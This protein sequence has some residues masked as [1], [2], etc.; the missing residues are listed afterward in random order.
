MSA[1]FA[2]PRIVQRYIPLQ[3]HGSIFMKPELFLYITN[4][5]YCQGEVLVLFSFAF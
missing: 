2:L 5:S 3:G 4:V 1:V